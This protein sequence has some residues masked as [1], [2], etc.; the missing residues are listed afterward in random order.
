MHSL[1]VAAVQDGPGR[2]EGGRG[3]GLIVGNLPGA[4]AVRL[5]KSIDEKY[6]PFST[7]F[8]MIFVFVGLEAVFSSNHKELSTYLSPSF[9]CRGVAVRQITINKLADYDKYILEFF[10]PYADSQSAL[11]KR[12]GIYR[13]NMGRRGVGTFFF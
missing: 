5:L 10:Y 1:P 8:D 3:G 13:K 6:G 9:Y 4:L 2:E 7:Y 12:E 11:K